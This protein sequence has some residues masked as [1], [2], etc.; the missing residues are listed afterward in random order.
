MTISRFYLEEAAAK[1]VGYDKPINGLG[2]RTIRENI[3]IFSSFSAKSLKSDADF[4]E[5]RPGRTP[6]LVLGHFF[7]YIRLVYIL[8]KSLLLAVVTLE[9]LTSGK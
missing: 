5:V 2:R 4:V 9:L 7:L 8:V 6:R 1:N 3:I